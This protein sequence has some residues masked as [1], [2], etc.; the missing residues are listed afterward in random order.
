MIYFQTPQ[1]AK[2]SKELGLNVDTGVGTK[3]LSQ[4]YLPL[5]DYTFVIVRLHLGYYLDIRKLKVVKPP[6]GMPSSP[7]KRRITVRS[8]RQ[9]GRRKRRMIAVLH[10]VEPLIHEYQLHLL[11]R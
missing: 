5:H 9:R 10:V 1:F 7:S 11:I 2:D 8:C 3:W 4:Y 6:V